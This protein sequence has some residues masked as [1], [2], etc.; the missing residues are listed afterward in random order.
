[1][2]AKCYSYGMPALHVRGVPED[3][4]EALRRRAK[5][6]GRSIS[7]ETIAILKSAVAD[8]LIAR[9]EVRRRIEGRRAKHG[10]LA[11]NPVAMVRED[12]DR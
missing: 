8:R 4:Y 9:A 11:V 12:R 10:T 3:V 6:Q 1:M 2:L 5:E 7:S